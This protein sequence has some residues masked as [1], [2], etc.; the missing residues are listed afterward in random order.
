MLDYS[1]QAARFLAAIAAAVL[2]ASCGGGDDVPAPPPFGSTTV[3]FGASVSDTG[4]ACNLAAANCPPSPPYAQGRNSNGPLWVETIAARYGASATPSRLNG[5]DYAYAGATTGTVPGSTATRPP[6]MVQQV[7]QYLTRVN[8]Q[9]S[10]STL[11]ILDGITVG[12]NIA[13]ALTQVLGGN[14]NAPTAV[15]TQAVTDIVGIINRLYA[16]GARTIVFVN[17]VDIGK[18]PRVTSLGNPVATAGATQMSQQFN[19]AVAQQ[20]ATIRAG[21]PGL[22]LLIVDA[23]ALEAGIQA[24]PGANGFTN[25]TA[26]CVVTTPTVSVC[27]TPDTYYYWDSFHPTFTTGQRLAQETI[28]VIGR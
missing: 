21:A 6:S 19:G 16:A 17:S 20:I 1:R 10:P 25:V 2:L 27:S 23:Y 26:P 4:N 18:T 15:I 3:V 5:F 24:A 7:D 12:N 11:F 13:D 8:F 9:I 22:T 28:R 14:A